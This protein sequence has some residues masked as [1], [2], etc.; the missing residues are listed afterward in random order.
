M[1][2]RD[3]QAI[4]FCLIVWNEEKSCVFLTPGDDDERDDGRD[5]QRHGYDN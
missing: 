1:L 5:E 4:Q 3:K 2:A